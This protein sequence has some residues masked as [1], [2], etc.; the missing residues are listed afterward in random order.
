MVRQKPNVNVN[1]SALNAGKSNTVRSTMFFFIMILFAVAIVINMNGKGTA[2]K[3]EVP[4][5]EV[6]LRAHDPEG[7]F[8]MFT[9]SVDAL[10]ISL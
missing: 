5:S 8:A 1:G 9:V 6:I 3:T 7:K 10:E 4:I 2:T